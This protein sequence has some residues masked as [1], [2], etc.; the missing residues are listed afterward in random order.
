MPDRVD[1]SE[2]AMNV[3][4]CIA[5]AAVSIALS[6]LTVDTGVA[7]AEPPIPAPPQVITSPPPTGI[8]W[9]WEWDAD[10]DD[11]EQ[12]A[13]WECTAGWS[14]KWEDNYCRSRTGPPR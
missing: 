3:T 12:T 4:S 8:G 11:W 2:V 10:D 14:I 9:N 13:T 7:S 5:A 1:L 6:G